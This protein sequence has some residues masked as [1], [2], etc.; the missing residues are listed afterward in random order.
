MPRTAD[1]LIPEGYEP[2]EATS[3]A[4]PT[5][6]AADRAAVVAALRT[7]LGGQPKR[8]EDC[9]LLAQRVLRED[10]GVYV[11]NDEADTLVTSIE[12]GWYPSGVPAEHTA[13]AALE[14][15]GGPR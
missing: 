1:K 10:R 11:T 15:V 2:T 5:I 6:R 14:V 4:R 9:V 8:W 7:F 3:V 13:A 12:A